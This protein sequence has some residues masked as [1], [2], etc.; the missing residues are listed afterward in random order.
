MNA[1]QIG[2]SF[3]VA[4]VSG[5]V[6]FELEIFYEQIQVRDDGIARKYYED[7]VGG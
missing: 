6:K 1:S 5:L 2:E 3:S 4:T 7:L